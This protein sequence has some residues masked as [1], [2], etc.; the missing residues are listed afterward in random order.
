MSENQRWGEKKK[1]I[2]QVELS[3]KC[4]MFVLPLEMCWLNGAG[5]ASP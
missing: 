3:G 5:V 4:F 2:V 1:T